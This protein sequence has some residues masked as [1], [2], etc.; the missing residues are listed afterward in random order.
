M[1]TDLY[2]VLKTCHYIRF[3]FDV[4]LYSVMSR[5]GFLHVYVCVYTCA[6]V[7]CMYRC[8]HICACVYRCTYEITVMGT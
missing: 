3:G 1:Q 8:V 2:S 6:C 5:F 7:V 4:K